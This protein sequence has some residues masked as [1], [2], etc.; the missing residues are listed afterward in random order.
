MR[1]GPSFHIAGLEKEKGNN[2]LY[3]FL[4]RV[5]LVLGVLFKVGWWWWGS[6]FFF[7]F[8][9]GPRDYVR[10]K[11][12]APGVTRALSCLASPCLHYR[13]GTV[14]YRIIRDVEEPETKTPNQSYLIQRN[15][16]SFIEA[17]TKGE[18][19]NGCRNLSSARLTR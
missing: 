7:S 18:S 5:S 6:F 13:Y 8:R 12:F 14:L 16:P 10:V 15:S 4:L 11:G 3:I 1:G 19:K 2:F 9:V 17:T